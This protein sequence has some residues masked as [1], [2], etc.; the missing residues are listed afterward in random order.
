MSAAL[1]AGLDGVARGLEPGP[2]AIG[3]LRRES[4][5]GVRVRPPDALARDLGEA[6]LALDADRGFLE[7]DD[8]FAPELID[9]LLAELERQ[10]HVNRGLPHPNEFYMY[11]SV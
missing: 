4:G 3:D 6:V 9:A 2:P 11:F 10:L 8:V 1:C 5:F 7:R